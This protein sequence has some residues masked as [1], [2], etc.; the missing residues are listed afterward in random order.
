MKSFSPFI[1]FFP[2]L[3]PSLSFCFVGN[4]QTSL[5]EE[6]EIQAFRVDYETRKGIVTLEGDAELVIGKRLFKASKIIYNEKTKE[7][8]AEGN[9]FFKDGEDSITCEKLYFHMEKRT[10]SIENG[11][12][13]IKK[14]NYHIDGDLIEKTGESTYCIR[15]GSLTTCRPDRPDW[16]F[17]AK[18]AHIVVGGYAKLTKATFEVAGKPLFYLPWGLFPVKTERETGLLMPD[19]KVSGRDGFVFSPSLFWAI[20][21][22]KDATF[23]LQYIEKR[24]IKPGIEFRYAMRED[25]RGEWFSSILDDR[26]FMNTRYEIKGEHLQV[27]PMKFELKAKVRHTSDVDYLMDFAEKSEEKSESLLKSDLYVERPFR[28]SHMTGEVSYFRDLRTKDNDYTFKYLPFLSFFS[29]KIPILGGMFL[30]NVNSEFINFYREKGSRYARFSF[31]PSI[32]KIHS[33]SGLNLTLS[34]NYYGKIYLIERE[35]EKERNSAKVDTF[36]IESSLNANFLRSYNP[37]RIIEGELESLIRPNIRW[38]YIPR[39][40]FKDIP[41]IDPS[42]RF[43]ETNILTYSFSHYL[44][45]RGESAREISEFGIEQSYGLQRKLKPS[46]LY[47]GYGKRFSDLKGRLRFYGIENLGFTN[48][49]VVNIYGEGLRKTINELSYKFK[50]DGGFHISHTYT[51]ETAHELSLEMKGKF[52]DFFGRFGLRY[53][54]LNREWIDT[55]YE[56][57]YSPLCWSLTLR[58][59]QTKRPKDTSLRLNFDLKGITERTR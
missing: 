35:M 31:E 58:L 28:R 1:L 9:V 53:S 8:F 5:K 51:K 36:K 42:D 26:K 33:F 27:L 54:F 6:L 17:R 14:G 24:G 10:G 56:I 32:S 2:L 21:K 11:H 18:N 3:F 49:S 43:Y 38:V 7:L 20:D 22:D 19:I 23:Y 40:S 29:E 13:Y 4:F 48:E 41:Y 12:I 39:R 37:A 46:I 30:F 15:K 25:K 57:T 52:H 44:N 47:E 59:S 50:E 16:R 55:S 45:L 34:G